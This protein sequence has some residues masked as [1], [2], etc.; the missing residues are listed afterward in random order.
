MLDLST[1]NSN[2]LKAVKWDDGPLLVLAGPGSGKTRVLTYRIANI[3]EQTKGQHFRLLALTFTNKAAAEMR[4]RVEEIVPTEPNRVRLTTFHSFAAELLRQHGSAVGLSPSFQILSSEDDRI[5][6][7]EEVLSRLQGELSSQMPNHFAGERLLPAITRL[8]DRCIPSDDVESKLVEQGIANAVPLARVYSAYRSRLREIN[9]LDFPSLIAEALELI[10]NKPF[11]VK[12][13]RKVYKHILVD[14]FQDTNYSQ[15]QFLSLLVEPDYSTLFVVADDDQIIYQWN[16]ASPKRIESLREKFGVSELQLPESYRCPSQVIDLA[17][18][19][20]QKNL[21]RSASRKP[22]KSAKQKISNDV[23]RIYRFKSID[24]EARWIASS[25]AK[26]DKAQL[27]KCAVLARTRKLLEIVG[28]ELEGLGVPTY[29]AARKG[30]FR[31]A[32]FRMLHSLLRLAN[33]GDDAKVLARLSKAFYEI[34]GINISPPGIISKATVDDKSFLRTWVAGVK[35]QESVSQNTLELLNVHIVPL[36]NSLHYKN[37][38]EHFLFWADDYQDKELHGEEVFNEYEEERE[39]WTNLMSDISKKFQG[40][41]LSLYEL[42]HELDLSSKTPPKDPNAVTCFTIHASKGM[43]F[44]HVYLMGL[45]EDQLPSWAAVKKGN[46]SFAMQEERRN[47]FVGITRAQESLTLTYSD[48]VF[49]W[50]KKPSRFI[51]EM[52][53]DTSKIELF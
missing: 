38:V 52:G 29:F 4:N 53:I 20:I 2:Q 48:Y 17:N 8:L 42:L 1:L 12:H 5:A 7:L 36:I 16:G 11:L 34:E 44:N 22:L 28:K 49:G 24:L 14:E 32:P 45:V 9:A 37:F 40:E 31:S 21:N 18:S 35:M 10:K 25:I 19:L 27:A 51:K 43:E 47:C 33:S 50:Q 15:Y 6:V 41:E 23:V 13:I 3:L 46:D 39:V 26:R 30:E